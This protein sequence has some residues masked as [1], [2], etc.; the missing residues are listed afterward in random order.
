MRS[1]PASSRWRWSRSRS[2]RSVS[3]GWIA[4]IRSCAS[5]WGR[6]RRSSRGDAR[7]SC[8]SRPPIGP[9]SCARPPTSTARSS[10]ATRSSTARTFAARSSVAFGCGRRG[11]RGR[12]RERAEYRERSSRRRDG[13]SRRHSDRPARR[14]AG[15]RRRACVAPPGHGPHLSV[16]LARLAGA[17]APLRPGRGRAARLRPARRAAGRR[18]A[19]LAAGRLLDRCCKGA[20]RLVFPCNRLLLGWSRSRSRVGG[21][22][23]KWRRI[24]SGGL[25]RKATCSATVETGPRPCRRRR[26]AVCTRTL[27]CS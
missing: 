11:G 4:Q 3:P 14:P 13:R 25:T 16:Q 24:A 7:S 5:E 26:R 19:L 6:R 27:T 2:S 8:R 22:A 1:R 9:T 17:R 18:R 12:Q 23:R 21:G 10:R 20:A 15:G